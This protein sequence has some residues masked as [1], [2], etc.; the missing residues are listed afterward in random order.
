M[1]Q[2]NVFYN[3]PIYYLKSYFPQDVDPLFPASPF[4]TSV[5]GAITNFKTLP[6]GERIYP[7]KHEWPR[8]LVFF[9]NLLQENGVRQL[10]D[11]IGYRQVWKGGREWEGEGKRKGGVM[12]WKWSSNQLNG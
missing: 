8:Y 6:S 7:W 3:S 5:P 9:G 2:T 4:P 11:E 12:V 1:D 10:L